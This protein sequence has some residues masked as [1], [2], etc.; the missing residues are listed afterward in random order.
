MKKHK[1]IYYLLVFPLSMLISTAF[2]QTESQGIKWI[3]LDEALNA[4]AA[5]QKPIFVDMY[6]DWSQWSKVMDKETYQDTRVIEYVNKNYLAVRL[7]PEKEGSVTYRKE[8]FSNRSF[9]NK[10]DVK[11]YPSILLLDA[12]KKAKVKPGYKRVDSF[13]QMLEEY[14]NSKR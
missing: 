5:Q 8:T 2:I 10:F 12:K 14:K 6:T 1:Y 7:N 4:S 9:A 11:S 3:S 13:L